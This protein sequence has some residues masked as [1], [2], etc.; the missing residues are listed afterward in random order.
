MIGVLIG[1]AALIAALLICDA[2][3]GLWDLLH[4]DCHWEG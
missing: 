1:A 3:V 2:L 4:D